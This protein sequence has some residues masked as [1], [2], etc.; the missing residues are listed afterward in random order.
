MVKLKQDPELN[1]IGMNQLED[2]Q[3]AI[4]VE[5]GPPPL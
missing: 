4:I 5:N 3:I 1:T 2:G